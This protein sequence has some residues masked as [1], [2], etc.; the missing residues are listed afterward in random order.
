M[1]PSFKSFSVASV[2]HNLLKRVTNMLAITSGCVLK[3]SR[4]LASEPGTLCN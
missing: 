3:V 4:G 1:Q 2:A